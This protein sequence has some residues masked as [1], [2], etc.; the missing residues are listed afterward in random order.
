MSGIFLID[1]VRTWKRRKDREKKVRVAQAWAK[2]TGEV[3]QWKIV[4]ADEEVASPGLDTQIEAAFHFTVNG[5]YFGGYLRSVAMVHH[6]AVM[7]AKGAQA[8]HLR[9]DPADPNATAVFAEDNGENLPFRMIS[10]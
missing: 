6:E 4:A 7:K 9:Y 10:G 8:V 5:E 1:S 2:A 3:N